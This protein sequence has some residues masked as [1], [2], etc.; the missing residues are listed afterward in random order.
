M[1]QVEEAVG[2]DLNTL[3]AIDRL[4]IGSSERRSFLSSAIAARR[5]YKA[6]LDGEPVGFMVLETG[7]SG[8]SFISF[9]ITHPGHRRAGVASALVDYA[10]SHAPT[11]KLFTSTSTGNTDMQRLC[12]S[13]GFVRVGSFDNLEADDSEI[14]YYKQIDKKS[15]AIGVR[16]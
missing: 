4:V 14:V 3:C 5:C 16:N 7:L 2:A 8:H 13:L 9:M 10:E 15:A 12:E 6:V 11:D 1:V